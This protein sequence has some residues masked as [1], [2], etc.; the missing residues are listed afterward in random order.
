[1]LSKKKVSSMDNKELLQTTIRL[2]DSL[3]VEA[4]SRRG[5]TKKTSHDMDICLEELCQRLDIE[6]NPSDWDI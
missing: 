3:M 4:N 6:Y 1:M 2:E 5:V